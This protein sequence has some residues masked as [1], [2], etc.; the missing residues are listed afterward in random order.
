MFFIISINKFNLIFIEY[1]FIEYRVI[2]NIVK[3]LIETYLINLI[4]L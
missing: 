1:F 4:N 2:G 3:V